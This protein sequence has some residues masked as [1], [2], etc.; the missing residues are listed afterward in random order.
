MVIRKANDLDARR[1]GLPPGPPGFVTAL[2]A[3]YASMVGY[4]GQRGNNPLTSVNI[5]TLISAVRLLQH[6][7]SHEVAPFVSAW[8]AAVSEFPSTDIPSEP[9]HKIA[10]AIAGG[11]MRTHVDG[12]AIS[13]H[14]ATIARAAIR[15][16]ITQPLVD[17]EQFVLRSLVEILSAIQTVDYLYPLVDL[18]GHQKNGLDVI[19]LNYDLTVE[20]AAQQRGIKVA[21]G[22]EAWQPGSTVDLP[23]RDGV[24]NLLKLHGSLDWRRERP[25]RSIDPLLTPPRLRVLD[26]QAI[27]E[28]MRVEDLPWIVVGDREKL[29]TDGPTLALHFAARLALLRATHLTVVGYSF[30]DAHINAMIRDWLAAEPSRTISILDMRWE[31]QRNWM[32]TTGFRAALLDEY[33]R[34]RDGHGERAQPR[35][36]AVE[37]ATRN[38]LS[39]AL[40]AR[41]LPT[42]TAL[43]TAVPVQDDGVLKIAVTWHGNDLVDAQLNASKPVRRNEPGRHVPLFPTPDQSDADWFQQVKVANLVRGDTIDVFPSSVASLPLEISVRGIPLTGSGSG[44]AVVTD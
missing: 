35:L 5:E 6:R 21:R 8:S 40:T 23:P 42:P 28:N 34:D 12:E 43:V 20:T 39:R 19:T 9:G 2:N 30:G 4:Q 14:I 33:G 22:I 1:R 3:V 36:V 24:L 27:T 13:R 17:A 18:A 10:E 25:T 32:R 15:P 11:L 41:P 37:G 29:A 26:P 38:E 44:S 7:D 31:R 16:D